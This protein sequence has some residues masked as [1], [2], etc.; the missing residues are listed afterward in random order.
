MKTK[1]IDAIVRGFH[2]KARA[3]WVHYRGKAPLSENV[4]NELVIRIMAAHIL[5]AGA[6]RD[7]YLTSEN[8]AELID[9]EE[10]E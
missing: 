10:A 1:E 7:V 8:S 5:A 9:S 3:L 6:T 2:L 4:R